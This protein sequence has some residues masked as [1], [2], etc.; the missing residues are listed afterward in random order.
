MNGATQKIEQ[1]ESDRLT[2]TELIQVNCLIF[3]LLIDIIS[4]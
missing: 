3:I 4:N 2:V 1:L